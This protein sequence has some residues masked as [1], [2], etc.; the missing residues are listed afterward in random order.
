MHCNHCWSFK[1][2][3]NIVPS[4]NLTYFI[5]TP[6]IQQKASIRKEFYTMPPDAFR[7]ELPDSLTAFYENILKKAGAGGRPVAKPLIC[8][9][10]TKTTTMPE[11]A[12]SSDADANANAVEPLPRTLHRRWPLRR[13]PQLRPP[14]NRPGGGG[15][16]QRA[17]PAVRGWTKG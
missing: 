9:F 2:T 13:K 15:A 10:V 3:L 12:P 7:T 16:D 14:K 17:C 6:I 11:A 8:K 5:K 4:K 1:H